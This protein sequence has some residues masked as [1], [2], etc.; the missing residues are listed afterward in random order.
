[1]QNKYT[2]EG[3]VYVFDTLAERSWKAST[4]AVSEAKAVSNLKY[5]FRKESG[6]VNNIPIKLIGKIQTA[7]Y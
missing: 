2:Y 7:K 3:P 6:L 1:M 5:R 4:I